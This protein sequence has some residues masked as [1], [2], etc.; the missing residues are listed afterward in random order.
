[1]MAGPGSNVQDL[2]KALAKAFFGEFTMVP[3]FS[4]SL[5]IAAK[6]DDYKYKRTSVNV[7]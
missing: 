1:M 7:C 4:L 6:R 5:L 2:G 3:L